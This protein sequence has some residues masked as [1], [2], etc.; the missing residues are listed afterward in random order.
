MLNFDVFFFSKPFD[1]SEVTAG[2]LQRYSSEHA[3]L[4]EANP[5]YAHLAEPTLVM[6]EKCFGS[7]AEE[8]IKTTISEN[9]TQLMLGARQAFLAMVSQYEGGVRMIWGKGSPEYQRFYPDGISEYHRANLQNIDEKLI[10]YERAVVEFQSKLPLDFVNAFLALPTED[11]PGGVI[12]RFRAARKLQLGA[13]GDKAQSGELFDKNRA[14]L[15]ALLLRNLL[16]V[17]TEVT[18]GSELEKLEARRLFPQHILKKV[19]RKKKGAKANAKP[20][21]EDEEEGGDTDTDSGADTDTDTGGESSG[22]RDQ[23]TQDAVPTSASVPAQAQGEPVARAGTDAEPVAGSGSSAEASGSNGDS[24][25][26]SN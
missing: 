18:G 3:R 7:F 13:K 6:H 20:G 9:S 15:E 23:I 25:E 16:L 19:K 4:M 14:L 24:V 5:R 11:H 10:R 12:H 17:A 21:N 8:D 1:L 26:L 2:R 22:T